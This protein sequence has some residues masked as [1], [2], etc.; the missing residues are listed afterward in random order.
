M[1]HH[2]PFHK[3]LITTLQAEPEALLQLLVPAASAKSHPGRH[4][5]QSIQLGVFLAAGLIISGLDHSVIANNATALMVMN[6]C[7]TAAL[8][9]SLKRLDRQGAHASTCSC[10]CR[11]I[12]RFPSS[13]L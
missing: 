4:S 10:T 6:P 8:A 2:H 12:Q 7:P 13:S 5:A 11:Q 3:T 9:Q 1:A